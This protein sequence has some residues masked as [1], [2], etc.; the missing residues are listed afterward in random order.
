MFKGLHKHPFPVEAHLDRSLVLGFALPKESLAF[1]IPNTMELDLFKDRWAFLAVAMVQTSGLRPKGFPAFLGRDFFLVGYRI[2][3]RYRNQSGRKLRGLYILGSGTNR[4]SMERLG[5]LFTTYSYHTMD[6]NWSLHE[7]IDCVTSSSGFLVKVD[8]SA[9]APD[10]PEGSPFN[11]W[12]E[13]RRFAGPM[14]FT[15]S[16]DELNREMTIIEG[17]RQSWTPR[18]VSVIHWNI[19]FLQT[20]EFSTALLANAFVVENVPYHWKKGVIEKC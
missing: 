1:C 11:D 9:A 8:S 12:R 6:I 18:P 5:S 10:L 7:G 2:M 15:F 19:P 17:A 14:P 4:R 3:V 16:Y 20:K 13:A